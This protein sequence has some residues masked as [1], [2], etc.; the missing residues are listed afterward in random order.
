MLRPNFFLL[1]TEIL[2]NLHAKETRR[3][4]HLRDTGSHVVR[5][6][7]QQFFKIV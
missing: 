1:L 5:A 7:M 6:T 3:L 4:L 2:Q